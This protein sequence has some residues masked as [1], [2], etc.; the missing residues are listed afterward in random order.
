MSAP[1]VRM[2]GLWA[3]LAMRAVSA[4]VLVPVAIAM[5]W[6]GGVWFQ[7]MIALAGVLAAQEYCAI[8][9]PNR[10]FQFLCHVLAVLVG[11]I[12]LPATG[13]IAA[14]VVIG[15][16]WAASN[17]MASIQKEPVSAWQRVGVIYIAGPVAALIA[18][19][20]SGNS[21][22]EA[23]ILL[24][25]LVWMSDV[26]AYFFGR[27]IGGP[28]LVPRISPKKT[29]SGM[30][31]AVVGSVATFV[32]GFWI[33]GFAIAPML[34]VLAFLLGV[35]EQGGDIIE[36]AFKR[37]Y[38][39]KDSGSLIPGHGGMLDRIDGLMAVA[40]I[41]ALVGLARSP[42]ALSEGILSW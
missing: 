10:P 2:T 41:A 36:S 13:F 31:G 6:Q 32:V 1:P 30:L 14:S 22:F 37:S 35:V 39:V 17:V 24:F 8:A 23:T 29:W 9:F 19:R 28:K 38:D 27:L 33:F 7:L 4:L 42:N 34:M 21:G 15:G 18:I 26:T 20:N 25:A 16:A 3:D 12:V 5:I 11:V 40:I